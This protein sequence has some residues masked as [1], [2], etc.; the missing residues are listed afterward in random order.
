MEEVTNLAPDNQ[1][2][3]EPTPEN[4]V[5]GEEAAAPKKRGPKG[6]HKKKEEALPLDSVLPRKPKGGKEAEAKGPEIQKD[7]TF[8]ARLVEGTHMS[9]SLMTGM[10]L[11]IAPKDAEALGAAILAVVKEYDLSFISKYAPML[12]LVAVT[13][14]VEIPIMMKAQAG[15]KA[16][17]ARK[18]EAVQAVKPQGPGVEA[19]SPLKVMQG[20]GGDLG[21]V[22]PS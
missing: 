22:Y 5:V 18:V 4:A 9:L 16:K 12:N 20:G 10:D 2:S 14:A 8:Y 11:T 17:Q 21:Q 1:N 6:P 3:P 7:A 13:A 19:G 15:L